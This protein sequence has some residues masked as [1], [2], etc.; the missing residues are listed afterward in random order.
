MAQGFHK[1]SVTWR[2]PLWVW[3]ATGDALTLFAGERCCVRS[4]CRPSLT[5]KAGVAI[6]L[7]DSGQLRILAFR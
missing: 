5:K 3:S 4:K 6:H 1:A 2:K 7:P